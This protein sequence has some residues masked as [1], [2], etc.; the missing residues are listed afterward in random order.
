MAH[1]IFSLIAPY[2]ADRASRFALKPSHPHRLFNDRPEP[3][4]A[5]HA[6]LKAIHDSSVYGNVEH[7]VALIRVI[8]ADATRDL[9]RELSGAMHAAAVD[10]VQELLIDNRLAFQFPE[11][12]P[13]LISDPN[14]A[15]PLRRQLEEYEPL[16]AHHEHVLETFGR[17][18]SAALSGI[19]HNYLP[20]AAFG[21]DT[22]T[23]SVSL[24]TLIKNP[25][26]LVEQIVAT[27]INQD[28]DNTTEPYSR[29]FWNALASLDHACPDQARALADRSRPG[30]AGRHQ[31]EQ[32]GPRWWPAPSAAG[33]SDTRAD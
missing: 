32:V 3:I 33:L 1:D 26:D 18:A 17:I 7:L 19:A 24:L 15:V 6:R 4:A 5:S 25:R 29:A 21:E 2:F 31:K 10:F 23:I 13:A 14:Y 16:L 12:D 27:F 9:P 8:I 28:Q 11:I 22:S 20:D 30:G